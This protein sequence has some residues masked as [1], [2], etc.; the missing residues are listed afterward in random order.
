MIEQRVKAGLTKLAS[1]R[2]I[3][4]HLHDELD[5]TNLEALR[6]LQ[7]QPTGDHLILADSQSAGRGRRGR[8][9]RSPPAA[10]LY[11]SLLHHLPPR[12]AG[13][14][15]LSLIAAL[16]VHRVLSR[17]CTTALYLKW[18]N[19][20]LVG[21]S[22]LAG[23]LLETRPAADS[24]PVVFGIGVN[25]AL[26]AAQKAQI[27]RPAV[28]LS[29]FCTAL[30]VREQLAARVCSVLYEHIEQYVAAGFAPFQT[31]WNRHDR[32]LET[33]VE[34][35][36]GNRWLCGKSLGADRD[37]ALIVQTARGKQRIV[38]G[39]ILPSVRTAKEN[40]HDP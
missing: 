12:K 15:A 23:I 4:V 18:P 30:P 7:A 35:D 32:H 17:L 40:F 6:L 20:L 37:G 16:S 28:A 36:C 21:D 31:D 29:E 13:L 1:S 24:F 27:D 14:Q 34:V 8:S 22:K 39:E 26:D 3:A 33:A 5:S 11:M 38:G 9:W 10:G 2:L 19:D 25:Y